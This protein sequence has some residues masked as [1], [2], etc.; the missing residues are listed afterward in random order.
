MAEANDE[1][2]WNFAAER[3]FMIVTKDSDFLQR[4]LVFGHPPK[5]IWI[6]RGNRSTAEIEALLRD[7]KDDILRFD[8][9][10]DQSLLFVS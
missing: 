10:P 7:R 6:R 9:D 5:V 1:R 3:G 4:S 8:T 2:V